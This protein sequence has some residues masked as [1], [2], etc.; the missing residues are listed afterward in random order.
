MEKKD[1]DALNNELESARDIG[2]FLDSNRDEFN[3]YT[4]TQYLAKLLAE[5]NMTKAGVINA[6]GLNQAYG[7]HIL[8]GEKH[9]SRNK[10]LAIALALQLDHKETQYLLKYAE[11]D[12]LYVRNKRD[13]VIIFALNKKLGVM[14]TNQVLEDLGEELIE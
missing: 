9:P 6:S 12:A 7:Y 10:V 5:K 3:N 1:T 14:E 2:G 13:S 11:A 8:S 4:L